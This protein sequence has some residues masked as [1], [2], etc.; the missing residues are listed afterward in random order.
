MIN[1]RKLLRLIDKEKMSQSEAARKLQVSRQAISKRLQE[2]R[3]RQ[4]RVVVSKKLEQAV[5]RKFDAMC[6]L[7]EINKKTMIAFTLRH[8]MILKKTMR[9][10][11]TSAK[12]GTA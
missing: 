10:N 12:F 11:A 7:A 4:T 5:D 8:H 9:L 3:G 2:L 1:D 6:Q